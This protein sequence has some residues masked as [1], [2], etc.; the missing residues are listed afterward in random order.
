MP[1][2]NNKNYRPV[3][4]SAN[5]VPALKN[6]NPLKEKKQDWWNEICDKYSEKNHWSKKD[7]KKK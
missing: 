1:A 6:G 2:P 7:K 3:N 5:Y 4:N